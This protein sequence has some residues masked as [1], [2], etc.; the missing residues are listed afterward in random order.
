MRLRWRS[1][2]LLAGLVS[3]AVLFLWMGQAGEENNPL[4]AA[5]PPTSSATPGAALSADQARLW[6]LER[7]EKLYLDELR[8]AGLPPEDNFFADPLWQNGLEI[9]PSALKEQL[10]Q[11]EKQ[12]ASYREQQ[13]QQKGERTALPDPVLAG[14]IMADLQDFDPLLTKLRE[15]SERSGANPGMNYERGYDAE[16]SHSTPLL[17]AGRI[18]R[19][20]VECQLAMGQTHAAAE[21]VRLIFRLAGVLA[22]EPLL[23]ALIV[24]VNV[25]DLGLR[26]ALSGREI[27]SPDVAE[28]L[29]GELRQARPSRHLPTA[30]RGERGAFNHQRRE[31]GRVQYPALAAAAEQANL[32][33]HDPEH[34][35]YNLAMQTW[36]DALEASPSPPDEAT[37]RQITARIETLREAQR[38]PSVSNGKPGP[39]PQL[40]FPALPRL[41]ARVAEVEAAQQLT[42]DLLS[43]RNA[44]CGARNAE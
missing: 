24:A 20:R 14:Q 33:F 27:W 23:I 21:D 39:S 19:L 9:I 34:L 40:R 28:A 11:N 41:I 22:Q 37:L 42:A 1:F 16:L 26:A 5:A 17:L 8:P 36:I 3:G 43:G 10:L 7:G 32:A 44:E 30:L 29:A 31:L 18:L 13:N 12:A 15:L 2:F 6:L 35:F 4:S 38:Q 25:Q